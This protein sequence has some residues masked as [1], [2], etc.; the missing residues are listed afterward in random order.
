VIRRVALAGAAALLLASP[1]GAEGPVATARPTA[2]LT[3]TFRASAE[4]AFFRWDFGDGSTAEGAVVEHVYAEA[5]RYRATLTTDAGETSVQAVAYRVAFGAPGRARYGSRG[6][7]TGSIWPAVRRARVEVLGPSGRIARTRTGANGGFAVRARLQGTG[8]FHARI[9][10]LQSAEARVLLRPRI[11]A[12]LVGSRIVGEPLRLTA[13]VRP[14]GAGTVSAVVWR[15]GRRA[16]EGDVGRGV[17]LGTGKAARFRVRLEVRPADG[18]LPAS[19]ALVGTV[20]RPALALGSR[21]PAVRAVQERLRELR[22]ALPGIDGS[23]S[24]TTYGAVLAFQAVEGLPRTG[25]IDA[26]T[27]RRL[28]RAHA[29]RARYPGSHLEIS[30]GRQVL[31]AVRN[32][33]VQLAVHVSTGATGNTPLGHWRIYRKVVGWDWVLWYPMYFLRG[34]AVHG[35]PDVPPYPASHGCI[36][37]PMWIAPTL[38]RDRTIG[39]SIYIYL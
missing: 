12:R 36:R 34:F 14:A 33:R 16:F 4:S 5:G 27:W 31:L 10:G 7:F 35:Y 3:V 24:L 18:Y 29:P 28:V 15:N 26:T 6:R 11:D 37:V 20:V 17:P 30:K 23:Y 8:P 22:Y 21:G 13:T 38:F 25:R 1:A 9:A 32:G 2:P 39:D 19:A